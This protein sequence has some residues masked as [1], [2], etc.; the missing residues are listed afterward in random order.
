MPGASE[1]Q[2]GLV[3][4]NFQN[5]IA[6]RTNG[7]QSAI[8]EVQR[9]RLFTESNMVVPASVST[10]SADIPFDASKLMVFGHSQ[11]GLNGP[12]FTAVDP[13]A[14]GGVFSG[15]GAEI[16]I[17]LLD[18]TSPQPSVADIVR[19][20]LGF[21]PSDASELDIFHPTMSLLQSLIDVEDPLNYG[22]LQATE[23]RPGFAS[24]SVYMTE[25]INPDG[26]GDTYAPP[27]GIEAHALSIGLP[28]QLPDEHAIPQVA[29]GG[30][31]P[32]TVPPGGL[33]GNLAGGAA[34]GI[35][36]QWP[37]PA[38]DDGHFVVFDVPA[39]REQAADF[40]QDLA[41][42]PH[43]VVPA[44]DV[45]PT[46]VDAGAC[47]PFAETFTP[48]CLGCLSASCCDAA[49]AC[50]NVSDCFGYVSCQQNCP[51]PSTG[52]SNTCLDACSQQFPM[53]QPTFGMMTACLQ[54]RCPGFCPY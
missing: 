33:S 8:D 10:S 40:L 35:L 4:Y 37:V 1:A 52:G 3:F 51:P 30:P 6:A 42:N 22:L 26:T 17:A 18:K 38:G 20:L 27:P 34:S 16:A 48:A 53:A 21:S 46:D 5:P 15:S 43:G 36:A 25:G 7:R 11:G 9:A 28:L 29:W 54:A 24:K 32:T 31:Q 12:L 47:T 14:R 41:A 39:A 50:F 19:A 49:V 44:P 13:A 45:G 23:P 2:I